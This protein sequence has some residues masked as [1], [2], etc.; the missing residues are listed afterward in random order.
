MHYLITGGSGYI[1]TRLTEALSARE[2]TERITIVDLRPPARV[3]PK[4]T[5]ERVDVRDRRRI[6]ALVTDVDSLVHL[7][8]VLNPMHDETR[9]YDIDVNGTQTVLEAAGEA[10]V[11]HVLVAS[12]TTAYGAWPDNP[13]PIAEDLPVRGMPDFAYARDKADAD[14]LC[15][16]WAA[17]HPESAMTIVR[18][19][20]VL[21]PGVDNYISRTFETFPFIASLDGSDEQVQ[22]VHEEDLVAAVTG[23]LD[24]MAPGAYNVTG[25]GTLSWSETA[26]IVGKPFRRI[27]FRVQYRLASVLWRLRA[28]RVE[29]P[30]GNLHFIRNPWVCS[31]DKLKSTIG[32]QPRYTS[33]ETFELAMSAKGLTAAAREPVAS[34]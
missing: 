21:G 8:F 12:S 20:I 29:A 24:A 30:P 19:C 9:M 25:D 31:N 5:F 18:P 15:Q 3:F 22:F 14:R 11:A 13:R 32:W 23:L 10:S 2:E 27:P 7:A 33:R 34:A 1:G 4:T 28:P 16:L 6:G 26:A 17:Q